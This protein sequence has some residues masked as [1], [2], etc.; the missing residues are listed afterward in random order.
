MDS[1]TSFGE[2]APAPKTHKGS[3]VACIILLMLLIGVSVF[4]VITTLNAQ[5]KINE[6]DKLKQ[7]VAA[8]DA[9]IKE[10]GKSL[11]IAEN[12]TVTP[13]AVSGKINRMIV[14]SDLGLTVAIPDELEYVSFKYYSND[15]FPRLHI[16]GVLKDQGLQQLPSYADPYES[17]VGM[18]V[19]TFY[20][21]GYEVECEASC[22][23]KMFTFNGRDVYYEGPQSAIS[24]DEQSLKVE[25]GSVEAIKKMLT[26][27]SSYSKI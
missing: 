6:I 8:K 4:A 14:I 11:G 23:E 15:I 24:Q 26:Q 5:D 17:E 13:E 20:P 27:E 21:E 9:T 19:V 18:G 22:A 12:E 16:W 2:A 3:L 7:D 1:E 25:T 10:I